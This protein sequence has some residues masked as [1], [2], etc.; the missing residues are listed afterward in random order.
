[1]RKYLKEIGPP[2]LFK[3]SSAEKITRA[4]CDQPSR[5]IGLF[6]AGL[7]MIAFANNLPARFA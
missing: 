3:Y 6:P 5:V 4:P 7:A 2:T 1:M